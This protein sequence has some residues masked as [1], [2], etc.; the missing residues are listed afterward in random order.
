MSKDQNAAKIA[1]ASDALIKQWRKTVKD[2]AELR[3]GAKKGT[4]VYQTVV[5]C[6]GDLRRFEVQL[7]DFAGALGDLDALTKKSDSPAAKVGAN[8]VKMGK[9]RLDALMK[10]W[11]KNTD[12]L[13]K[14]EKRLKHIKH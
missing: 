9:A 10:V 2:A 12:L 14:Y 11:N 4:P 5:K 7:M 6:S 3:C 8:L 13:T 1:K